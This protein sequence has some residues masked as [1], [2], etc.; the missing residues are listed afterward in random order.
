MSRIRNIAGLVVLPGSRPASRTAAS[1]SR[2]LDW[3]RW[4]KTTRYA[5]AQRAGGPG[6]CRARRSAAAHPEQAVVPVDDLDETA[7]GSRAPAP[8]IGARTGASACS[9]GPSCPGPQL[10]RGQR[11]QCPGRA[12]RTRARPGQHG[13]AKGA[14]RA[15]QRDL[16]LGDVRVLPAHVRLQDV[17]GVLGRVLTSNRSCA[18]Y[19]AWTI[20]V[21][22]H[23]V[24]CRPS[25]SSPSRGCSGRGRFRVQVTADSVRR[26]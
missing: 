1:R 11:D 20:D 4:W 2:I 26:S 15:I 7:A 19:W 12:P 9:S 21:T 25:L 14:H 23:E 18:E 22:V 24:R 16:K 13:Y 8:P 17:A 5:P 10:R 3:Y 6:F